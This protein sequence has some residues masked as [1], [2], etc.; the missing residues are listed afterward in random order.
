MAPYY[1][2]FSK[3]IVKRP[4]IYFYDT[5]L[6]CFLLGI[7]ETNDVRDQKLWGTLFENLV[8]A[9]MIKQNEHKNLLNSYYFWRDAAGKEI[10]LLTKRGAGYLLYQI[11]STQTI[12]PKLFEHMDYF[13]AL[14]DNAV[15]EKTLI[16]GGNQNQNRTNYKVRV[17]NQV[18]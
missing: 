7:R 5:G 11:K 18:L 1:E 16:Y 2:N 15:L 8:V 17:W 9:E 10:D 3:R 12:T 6:L 4:K 14:S 13:N